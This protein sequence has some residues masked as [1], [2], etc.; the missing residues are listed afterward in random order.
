MLSMLHTGGSVEHPPCDPEVMGSITGR[1]IPK[2]FKNS[3]HVL[4][5][6]LLGTRQ[7]NERTVQN[8]NWSVQCYY[9]VNGWN[10]SGILICHLVEYHFMCLGTLPEETNC[11]QC[12]SYFLGKIR[13]ILTCV[14]NCP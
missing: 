3:I 5:C 4:S 10:T 8:L 9:K 11:I 13:T 1:V 14:L 6:L 7:S 12:E 2:V